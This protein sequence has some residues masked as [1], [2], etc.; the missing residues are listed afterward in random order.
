MVV[1]PMNTQS[2]KDGFIDVLIVILYCTRKNSRVD[3]LG[4]SADVVVTVT[5]DYLNFV[6]FHIDWNKFSANQ[7][8][9]QCPDN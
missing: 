1:Y 6:R 3:P 9:V 5:S 7:L 4:V 8:I 2:N